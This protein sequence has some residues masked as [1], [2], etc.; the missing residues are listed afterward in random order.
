MDYKYIEQLLERYWDCETS[1][2]EE[3]ILRD[4][5]AQAEVPAH[6]AAYK[7]LF[8]YQRAE[9]QVSLSED[10]E[11]RLLARVEQAETPVRA[12]RLTLSR[13]LR[14]L[15]RAAA[16]VAIVSLLGLAA[17]HSFERS[18]A[19][20]GWDYSAAG[21]S[22]SYNT[23]EA[24]LDSC[25]KVLEFVQDGLKTAS[26]DSARHSAGDAGFSKISE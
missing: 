14:P 9:A 4:F 13:R 6:L 10:F 24:A 3:R 26:A 18:A 15:Y 2:E 20:E 7:S 8:D 11:A 23:P 16:S 12:R 17:Q 22:D 21:Y 1:V 5:F 25:I 19:P